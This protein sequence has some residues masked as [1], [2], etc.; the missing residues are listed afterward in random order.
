MKIKQVLEVSSAS[1]F[2]P[3]LFHLLCD[4]GRVNFS[5]LWFPLLKI[6]DKNIYLNNRLPRELWMESRRGR[7]YR[8]GWEREHF[9]SH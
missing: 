7:V 2:E 8:L 9:N 6:G 5:E 4:L 1:E 3:W